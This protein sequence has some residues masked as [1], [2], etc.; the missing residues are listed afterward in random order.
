MRAKREK[1][2]V[3]GKTSQIALHPVAAGFLL[4]SIFLV[5]SML[6]G[7]KGFWDDT[8]ET[9]ADWY[10]KPNA[11]EV[12][13][14]TSSS[15]RRAKFIAQLNEPAPNGGNSQQQEEVISLLMETA[16]KD[17]APNCRMQAIR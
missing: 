15:D 17:H 9:M 3:T 12:V 14:T 4:G 1:D 13:K 6:A 8:K 11:L 2:N 5:G 10:G 7:C 16:T